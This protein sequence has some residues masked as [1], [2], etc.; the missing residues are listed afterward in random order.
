MMVLLGSLTGFAVGWSVALCCLVLQN[1]PY[2]SF[3]NRRFVTFL[4]ILYRGNLVA[5]V[6]MAVILQL[7]M[8]VMQP[9][10]VAAA[11]LVTA[12]AGA[13]A[14]SRFRRLIAGP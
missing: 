11:S 4:K 13:F 9:P 7:V 14:L 5:I 8:V 3:P 1:A 10:V 2:G 12:A 6:I